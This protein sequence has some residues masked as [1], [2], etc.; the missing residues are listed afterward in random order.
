MPR[1]LLGGLYE[2]AFWISKEHIAIL[3]D[4][5]KK[6]GTT[7]SFIVRKALQMYLPTITSTGDKD[8]KL[9]KAY[10][11]ELEAIKSKKREAKCAKD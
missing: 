7:A 10:L 4:I 5:K 11:E 2:R 8:N 1:E 3:S 9:L 6:T